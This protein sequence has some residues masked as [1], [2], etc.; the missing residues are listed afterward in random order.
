MICWF[1]FDCVINYIGI[2]LVWVGE[3]HAAFVSGVIGIQLCMAQHASIGIDSRIHLLL[4]H[5]QVPAKINDDLNK[6]EMFWSHIVN[7]FESNNIVDIF[8]ILYSICFQWYLLIYK[9]TFIHIII[10]SIIIRH[11]GR[12]CKILSARWCHPIN[13]QSRA[14][15]H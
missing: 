2:V 6:V 12:F 1:I 11:D 7:E 3:W 9:Y 15:I 8:C 5:W 4:V 14:S 10:G 13:I